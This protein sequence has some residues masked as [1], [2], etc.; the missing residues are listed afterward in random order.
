MMVT[1][2][3]TLQN[4]A[5]A[6]ATEEYLANEVKGGIASLLLTRFFCPLDMTL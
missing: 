2:L 6:Y 5:H 1:P 3:A 4:F